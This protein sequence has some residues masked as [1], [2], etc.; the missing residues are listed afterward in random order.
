[1]TSRLM[2]MRMRM[3]KN[4][5]RPL[6][7]RHTSDAVQRQAQRH[8]SEWIDGRMD[9]WTSMDETLVWRKLRKSPATKVMAPVQQDHL[10]SQV[11]SPDH[12][13]FFRFESFYSWLLFS[14]MY[15]NTLNTNDTNT[16]NIFNTSQRTLLISAP[17]IR[18]QTGAWSGHPCHFPLKTIISICKIKRAEKWTI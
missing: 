2:R 4:S 7:H 5:N 8:R 15:S 14:F 6:L 1:M 17:G 18:G 16:K 10:G 3:R 9:G 12:S 13:C 11:C